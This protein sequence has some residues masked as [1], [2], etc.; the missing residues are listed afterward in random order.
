MAFLQDLPSHNSNSCECGWEPL[1]ESVCAIPSTFHNSVPFSMLGP[2]LAPG[3][4]VLTIRKYSNR[5]LWQDFEHV[6]VMYDESLGGEKQCWKSHSCTLWVGPFW[7]DRSLGR[8]PEGSTR[9]K[10]DVEGTVSGSFREPHQVIGITLIIGCWSWIAGQDQGLSMVLETR[11]WVFFLFVER[12]SPFNAFWKGW[13]RRGNRE[14]GKPV[15]GYARELV[16]VTNVS[17]SE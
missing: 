2:R 17:C 11:G 13:N 9:E 6:M 14:A 7:R 5:L 15:T 4:L 10:W 16:K 12:G 8:C 1:A 3:S